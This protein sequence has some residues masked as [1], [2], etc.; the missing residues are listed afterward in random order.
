MFCATDPFS[1]RPLSY[2]GRQNFVAVASEADAISTLPVVGDEV[3]FGFAA[4]LVLNLP[5][6]PGRTVFRAVH[7]LPA[8]HTVLLGLERT[9]LRRYWSLDPTRQVFFPSDGDYA[10]AFREKLT[11]AVSRRL[12]GD[13]PVASVL[14]GGLDSSSVTA[15]A[16]EVNRSRHRPRPLAL[17]VQFDCFPECDERGFQRLVVE[18]YGLDHLVAQLAEPHATDDLREALAWLGTPDLASGHWIT[19]RVASLTA[20]SGAR[21]LLTGAGGDRVVSHGEQ[22]LDELAASRQWRHFLREVAARS[23]SSRR[24]LRMMLV[25]AI[26][27]T[28]PH[29]VPKLFDGPLG[30]PNQGFDLVTRRALAASSLVSLWEEAWADAKV[31]VPPSRWFHWCRLNARDVRWDLDMSERLC[32]RLGVEPRHP[33]YDRELVEFCLALPGTQKRRG[34]ITRYVA[35][36]AAAREVPAAILQRPSKTG[37]NSVHRR[38]TAPVLRRRF[39]DAYHL[40]RLAPWVR[41]RPLRRLHERFIS[42][43]WK[44]SYPLLF[45]AWRV[46]LLS[47]WLNRFC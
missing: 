24:R 21:V 33:F 17:S 44:H 47:Y 12:E 23:S 43:R 41:A 1:V 42:D 14:S 27:G 6:A 40:E 46:A 2:F 37:F 18:K 32:S 10:D 11:V 15:L 34:Q 39:E 36:Q 9:S 3:D 26:R 7:R 13:Q 4:D 20:A 30:G 22:T 25:G 45:E 38:M 29:W 8:A 35:T 28:L 5:P 16:A 31:A 19:A